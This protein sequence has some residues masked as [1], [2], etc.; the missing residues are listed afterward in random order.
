MTLLVR[1]SYIRMH[2]IREMGVNKLTLVNNQKG[3]IFGLG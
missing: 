1:V 3:V 2:P